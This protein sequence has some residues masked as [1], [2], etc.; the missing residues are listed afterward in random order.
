MKNII[1]ASHRRSGTH[2]TID[3]I[4]NNFGSYKDN[5]EI[6]LLNLDSL[7]KHGGRKYSIK[8]MLAGIP[9]NGAVIKTHSHGN[10]QDFFPELPNGG[11]KGLQELLA[12]S[13]IIY[14]YRD[15]RDVLTSQYYYQANYDKSVPKRGIDTYVLEGNNFDADSY[16]GEMSRP[17]YWK[18]HVNSWINNKDVLAISFE[19]FVADYEA[20][21]RKIADFIEEPLGKIVDVRRKPEGKMLRIINKLRRHP[22]TKGLL[23]KK[24]TTVSF[25]KGAVGDWHNEFTDQ[26]IASITNEIGEDLKRLGY[27]A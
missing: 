17:E 7:T 19:E 24:Y 4:I 16:N 21:L 2:L 27:P 20:S 26:T 13:K 10:I 6:E 15:V 1:I 22:L 25:R 5:P 3:S 9:E 14:V 23:G 12:E 18:Y 11:F 8:E